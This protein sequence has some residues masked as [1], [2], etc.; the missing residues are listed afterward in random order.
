MES[1]ACGA[2]L[3]DLDGVL[4]DSSKS[5]LSHWAVWAEKHGLKIEDLI[6]EAHGVRTIDTIR[7][8][9]PDLDAEREAARFSAAEI[10]D[11]DGVVA[12]EGS[13]KLLGSLTQGTWG[14]VTSA[15]RGLALAR[16]QTAG[17]PIPDVLIGGD[18]VIRG[19]PDPEGYLAGARRLQ[20]SPDLCV[21]LEDSR[22]GVE[23]AQAAG[24]RVIGL[25]TTHSREAL[26]CRWV[27]KS[28]V[29]VRVEAAMMAAGRL[30]ICVDEG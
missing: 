19:K 13:A 7:R 9:A 21:A 8:V 5:V 29:A 22:A 11:T 27:V 3:F 16:L 14:I 17:L 20:T 30:V 28:L 23:A 25:A 26:G 15:S 24:M 4:I 1:L 18:E 2:L 12:L 6:P 10:A